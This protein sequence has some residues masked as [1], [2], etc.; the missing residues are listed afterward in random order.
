MAHWYHFDD[1]DVALLGQ[2]GLSREFEEPQSPFRMSQLTM[3]TRESAVRLLTAYRVLR[4]EDQLRIRLALQRLIRARNQNH[5]GNRASD[6]AIA[7]EGRQRTR[8][9]SAS[10]VPTL[11]GAAALLLRAGLG[12]P[13]HAIPCGQG[14]LN[15]R[16]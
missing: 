7:L 8:P 2:S 10:R 11:D 13:S 6:L 15:L 1:P 9:C 5:L 14:R 3:I 12:D 16:D 4:G